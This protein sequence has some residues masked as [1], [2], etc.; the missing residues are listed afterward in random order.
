MATHTVPLV[1]TALIIFAVLFVVSGVFLIV[2]RYLGYHYRVKLLNDVEQGR[3]SSKA[4]PE[5][6]PLRQPRDCARSQPQHPTISHTQGPGMN[7][8]HNTKPLP[9]RPPHSP[10]PQKPAPTASAVL[11]RVA[12]NPVRLGLG[13]GVHSDLPVPS[14]NRPTFEQSYFSDDDEEDDNERKEDERDM[15]R[16]KSWFL[17]KPFRSRASR[18]PSP[19]QNAETR[20]VSSQRPQVVKSAS[21]LSQRVSQLRW[22][23]PRTHVEMADVP[24]VWTPRDLRIDPPPAPT[25][26]RMLGFPFQ[27][28]RRQ[29][30]DKRT[31]IGP[32]GQLRRVS[33]APLEPTRELF[34]RQDPEQPNVI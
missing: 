29:S 10:R 28:H 34:A 27:Y 22:P 23:P 7:G 15:G 11:R 31:V 18:L 13:L 24:I 8:K 17:P 12:P 30:S 20:R 6:P 5:V 2:H 1:T 21:R 4:A 25:A 14:P 26:S 3:S 32:G 19:L 33:R 9:L 16:V